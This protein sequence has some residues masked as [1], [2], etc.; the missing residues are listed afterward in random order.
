MTTLLTYTSL[1]KIYNNHEISGKIA[2]YSLYLEFDKKSMVVLKKEAAILYKIPN[3][4]TGAYP[5]RSEK[6]IV[7][8]GTYT[9]TDF[10]ALVQ[11]YV[12]TFNFKVNDDGNFEMIVGSAKMTMSPN[13]LAAIGLDNLISNSWFTAG[14]HVAKQPTISRG[15]LSLICEELEN[16]THYIDGRQSKSLFTFNIPESGMITPRNLLYFPIKEPTRYL[17]L[18][19]VDSQGVDVTSIKRVFLQIINGNV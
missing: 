9:P 5:D 3:R 10:F 11:S 14:P 15:A 6:F 12:S 17:T 18:R 7:P 16:N 8:A 13:L 1:D 2:L 4:Q 19:L